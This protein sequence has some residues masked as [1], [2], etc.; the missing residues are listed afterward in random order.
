MILRRSFN[1]D[2]LQSH[3]ARQNSHLTIYK[4]SIII[5]QVTHQNPFGSTRYILCSELD[6]GLSYRVPGQ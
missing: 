2:T 1:F 5:G 6:R 4:Y 3:E